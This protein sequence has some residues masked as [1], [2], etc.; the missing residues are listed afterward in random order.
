MRERKR[1]EL[2]TLI[3]QPRLAPVEHGVHSFLVG[4]VE[5]L[6]E[7]DQRSDEVRASFEVLSLFGKT[8]VHGAFAAVFGDDGDYR[9]EVASVF[10][11]IAHQLAYLDVDATCPTPIGTSIS[12]TLTI[13]T[14]SGIFAAL[15]CSQP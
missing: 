10:A 1:T 11:M 6:G 5:D 3:A 14:R 4:I 13:S 8:G 7:L 9:A 2:Q 12:Q 15:T